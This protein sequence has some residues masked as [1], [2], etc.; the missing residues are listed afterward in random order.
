MC[1]VLIKFLSNFKLEYVE[2]CVCN[3]A[4]LSKT[5]FYSSKPHSLEGL[6]AWITQQQRENVFSGMASRQTII[7]S[8]PKSGKLQDLHFLKPFWGTGLFPPEYVFYQIIRV[9]NYQKNI[10]FTLCSYIVWK[11]FQITR[12]TISLSIQPQSNEVNASNNGIVAGT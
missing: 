9:K 4:R 5:A 12:N 7:M 1:T 10:S 8:K 11:L 2:A 6:G 3:Q